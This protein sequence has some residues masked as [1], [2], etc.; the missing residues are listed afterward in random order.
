LAYAVVRRRREIAVRVTLGAA[1]ADVL[2]LFLVEAAWSL[3]SVSSPVML[4]EG[5]VAES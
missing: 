4:R 3:L 5:A 1:C 2:W